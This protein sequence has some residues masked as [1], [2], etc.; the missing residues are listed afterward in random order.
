ME[1]V[2]GRGEDVE[3]DLVGK[4]DQ[5]AQLLEHL[6]VAFVVAA[7]RPQPPAILQRAGYRRQHQQHELHRSPPPAR[8]LS[9]WV[10]RISRAVGSLRYPLPNRQSLR[11]AA[12][13]PY[14]Q[15][16]S[17]PSLRIVVP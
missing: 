6:L 3:A 17:G 5:L 15:R 9:G 14:W 12:P 10:Q 1:V 13:L 2:L 8:C 16:G 11:R 7:D 4:D